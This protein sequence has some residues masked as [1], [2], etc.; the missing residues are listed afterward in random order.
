MRDDARSGKSSAF[1]PEVIASKLGGIIGSGAI[2][3]FLDG[4]DVNISIRMLKKAVQQ[5]R[6]ERRGEAY[7]CGTLSL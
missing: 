1:I 3:L 5:S 6:S 7:P 2:K 4:V